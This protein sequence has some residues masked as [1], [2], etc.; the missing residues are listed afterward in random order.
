MKWYCNWIQ[1]EHWDCN[2]STS[3]LLSVFISFSLSPPHTPTLLTSQLDSEGHSQHTDNNMLGTLSTLITALTSEIFFSFLLQQVF[4]GMT[5]NSCISLCMLT[6]VDA[7]IVLTQT[8]AV[9]T[10]SKGQEAVLNIQRDDSY[11]ACWYKPVPGKRLRSGFSSERFNSKA[12]SNIDYQFIAKWTEAGDTAV[13][14]CSTWDD[15]FCICTTVIH[16]GKKKPQGES[17]YRFKYILIKIRQ[18]KENFEQ[19]GHEKK[20][21]KET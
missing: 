7:V 15:C 17:H 18:V 3:P 14:Y 1:T 5:F 8:P 6:D 19:K 10:V 4:S 16:N 2:P 20:S 13:Y 9:H 21:S 11:C 12:S